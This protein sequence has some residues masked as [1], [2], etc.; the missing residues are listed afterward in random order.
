M[1]LKQVKSKMNLIG[2]SEKDLNY[3]KTSLDGIK[4]KLMI[5][6]VELLEN[7]TNL[8][9]ILY[10]HIHLENKKEMLPTVLLKITCLLNLLKLEFRCLNFDNDI[11]NSNNKNN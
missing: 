3:I 7:N 8:K 1:Y 5:L 9:K 6:K 11:S 4:I 2:H 10:L